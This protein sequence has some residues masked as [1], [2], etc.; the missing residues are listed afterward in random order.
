MHCILSPGAA[1]HIKTVSIPADQAGHPAPLRSIYSWL[2]CGWSGTS[3]NDEAAHPNQPIPCNLP[4]PAIAIHSLAPAWYQHGAP[5]R[6]SLRRRARARD[7]GSSRIRL[8][9][10]DFMRERP[11]AST[12]LALVHINIWLPTCDSCVIRN[13]LLIKHKQ[14]YYK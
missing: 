13:R 1:E 14:M 9:F 6:C 2:G 11:K 8:H 12:T 5:Q 10:R 7:R 4:S 3:S